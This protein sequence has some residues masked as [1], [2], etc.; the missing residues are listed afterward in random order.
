MPNLLIYSD[1]GSRGNPGPAGIGCVIKLKNENSK[2]K[3]IEEISE[4]IGTATNNQAEYRGVVAAL[5]FIKK[6][7]SKLIDGE[8]TI[9]IFLDSQLIVEQMNGK[10]KIRNE[11][12]KP[13]YWHIRELIMEL[14][15]R[16]VFKHITRDKNI[17]ADKLVNI[18]IDKGAKSV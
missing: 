16:I 11:G 3:V 5:E 9:E 7:K 14:G 8:M 2:L 18:A 13:L 17:E 1:G 12:L 4:Y 6:N 10:Y 15:G